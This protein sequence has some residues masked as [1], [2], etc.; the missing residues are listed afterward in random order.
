MWSVAHHAV[1][2]I[3]FSW[4]GFVDYY[5]WCRYTKGAIGAF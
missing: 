5:V 3:K 4:E 2:I 1:G